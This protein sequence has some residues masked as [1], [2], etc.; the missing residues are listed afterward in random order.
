MRILNFGSCNIDYVYSLPH[1]VTE[2]ETEAAERLEVF[3]GGKGLNQ[4]VAMARAGAEVFHAGCIGQEGTMLRDLLAESGAD[5]SCLETVNERNGHAIIQ[6]SERGENSILL[7]PGA[8]RAV[9]EEQIRR[10]LDR[11]GAGDVLVLQNEISHVDTLIKEG[12][13]R[14]M[15]IVLNPSP[16]NEQIEKIDLSMLSYLIL[17]EVE[18]GQLTGCDDPRCGLAMLAAQYPRLQVV[19]TLGKA[20]CLYRQGDRVLRQ[21]TFPVAVKDTT[22]AGDTFTG[23]FVASLARGESVEKALL[24]ASAAAAISV[25]RKGAAPSIP[26][27]DEVNQFLNERGER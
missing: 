6:V 5:V 27:C 14:G 3:P 4:S 2:G 25:S 16:Y 22:A 19:L 13:A 12:Y 15:R 1:I 10:V 9:T 24:T 26:R 23:Y 18:I 8:N 7:F 11:F 17:N 21:A 20:G